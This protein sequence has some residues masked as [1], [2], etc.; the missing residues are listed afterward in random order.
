[1]KETPG[2]QKEAVAYFENNSLTVWQ[3]PQ[4]AANK[5]NDIEIKNR[6][7]CSN[8]F[9]KFGH[10]GEIKVKSLFFFAC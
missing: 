8:Y 3:S 4:I 9:L 5:E 10:M 7:K 2:R 6:R 1:V